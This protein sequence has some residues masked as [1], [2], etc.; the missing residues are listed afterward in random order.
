MPVA[1]SAS[2]A[3][4]AEAARVDGE[5]GEIGGEMAVPGLQHQRRRVAGDREQAGMAERDQAA[6]ADQHVEREREHRQQ[7]DLARDVDV[8]GV[9][10]PH[11]QRRQS[12]TRDDERQRRAAARGS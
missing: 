11:R 4:T 10:D 8:I 3:N 7:Q 1:R 5:R 2:T 6:I 12:T 9:A